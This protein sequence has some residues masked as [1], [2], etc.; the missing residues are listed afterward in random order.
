MSN[1]NVTLVLA[2]ALVALLA[3]AAACIVVALLAVDVLG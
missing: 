1:R 2:A 3:G